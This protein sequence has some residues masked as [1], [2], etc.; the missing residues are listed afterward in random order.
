MKSTIDNIPIK[1]IIDSG[2]SHSS[3]GREVFSQLKAYKI[4]Q[5]T[6]SKVVLADKKEYRILKRIEVKLVMEG[7][8]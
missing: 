8:K 1:I 3:I 4:L 2:C 5:K 6:H 7:K